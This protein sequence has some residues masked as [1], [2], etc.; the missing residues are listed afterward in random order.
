MPAENDGQQR[1]DAGHACNNTPCPAV[2][3][4]ETPPMYIMHLFDNDNSN[5]KD[6]SSKSD[7]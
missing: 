4:Q 2:D 1:N 7:R 3:T 6:N 5:S